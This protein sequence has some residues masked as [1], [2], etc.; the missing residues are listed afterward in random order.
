LHFSSWFGITGSNEKIST[1][2]NC[3]DLSSAVQ[4]NCVLTDL[5]NNKNN[6]NSN[7]QNENDA[8]RVPDVTVNSLASTVGS[9]CASLVCSV[10]PSPPQSSV[11]AVVPSSITTSN[12]NNYNNINHSNQT[13]TQNNL[14][15]KNDLILG[16]LYTSS[17]HNDP[18]TPTLATTPLS[19]EANLQSKIQKIREQVANSANSSDF[20]RTDVEQIQRPIG[21]S[22]LSRQ[23]ASNPSSSAQ[24]NQVQNESLSGIV[25]RAK[26]GL[27]QQQQSQQ[28][29]ANNNALAQSK[30]DSFDLNID[31]TQLAN[32]VLNRPLVIKDLDF[33]DLTD[34]DDVDVNQVTA[35]PPPPPPPL[36]MFS[37]NG[38]GLSGGPPAPPPPPPP[39]MFGLGGPPAPPPPPPPPM[40]SFKGGA[41]P[42]PPPPMLSMN[43][44]ANKQNSL[45]SSNS[46]LNKSNEQENDQDKRKLIKLHWREAQLPAVYQKEECIWSSLN[47]I[48]ID[49]E[50]LSHLFELKIN[51]VK[52]KENTKNQN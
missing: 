52:T 17:S 45:A 51:E 1:N 31:P 50:K 48:E 33:T 5:N 29:S 20:T 42:P 16:K 38:S 47:S 27:Q 41:P 4:S 22:S 7:N 9:A 3:N 8:C 35:I 49:K 19:H 28:K 34:K 6:N 30:A 46:N 15:I 44:L 23:I 25:N 10:S 26:E 11:I 14:T 13:Q 43:S 37:M 12:L 40:G 39:P 36:P 18:T 24:S 21:V 2:P 32:K